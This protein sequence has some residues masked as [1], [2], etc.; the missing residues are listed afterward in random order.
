MYTEQ[1][2][3]VK[4]Y[5]S[6][7]E[8]RRI[9]VNKF[10]DE[11]PGLGKGELSSKYR[12]YVETLD[13]GRKIYLTR[14]AYLKKGFDFRINVERTRFLTNREYPKHED[15]FDDLR[16]KIKEN[17]D[18]YERLHE[19]MERVYNCEDPDNILPEYRDLKFDVGHPIDL[20]L[21]VSLLQNSN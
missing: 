20:I 1:K 16:A 3:T 13:D 9:V 11:E 15:V 21:K 7:E 4:D 17:P 18:A 19:V 10:L 6:R 5:H 12:Y 14:P 8:L 2:F